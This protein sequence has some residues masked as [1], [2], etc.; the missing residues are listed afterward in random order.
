MKEFSSRSL[1]R[2][3][4]LRELMMA[5]LSATAAA[6]VLSG[7]NSGG[8]SGGSSNS[9][10]ADTPATGVPVAGASGGKIRLGFIPLTDCASL[11]VADQKGFFKARGVDVEVVKMANWNAV[12]DQ[13]SSNQLQG[14]HCLFGM[15]FSL[16]TGVSRAAGDPLR[17]AMMINNNGQG[18]SLSNKFAGKVKY[19][20]FA[21]LG[22]AVNDFK[23]ANDTPT[24]G[25][26]FP[27]GTHD[28]WM[29][30]TLAGAG[31]DTKELPIKATPPPQ[32]VANMQ[33]GNLDGFNVGEPWNGRAVAEKIGFTFIATQDLWKNHPEKALVVNKTFAET[34]RDD[35]KKVMMAMLDASKFIDEMKNR[36]EVAE[37]IGTKAYVGAEPGVIAPRLLGDYDLGGGLGQKKFETVMAFHR[38]GDVNFPRHGHA[39][40][41]M[42]QYNRFG[43][44]GVKLPD[45]PMKIAQEVILQDLY[46]EVAGEM[47]IPVPDDDMKPF[48]VAADKAMF[49]PANPQA[50]LETY[51]ARANQLRKLYV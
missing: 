44:G 16:E 51:T 7:C 6:T 25:M 15:P 11:V 14:A 47:N 39:I 33:S 30:L 45:D 28:L 24:F 46:K 10:S 48:M 32:M 40:W 4:M 22:R 17:I 36:E 41:F 3:E 37:I 8:E 42:T 9:N 12:R 34:R 19:A 38:G 50:A 13:I 27:G 49:D 26:T 1:S 20:D 35:L 21:G 23:K 18:T 2:R 43:L 5:G 29:H 31:L